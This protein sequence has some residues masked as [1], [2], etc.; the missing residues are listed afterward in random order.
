M[1]VP[2]AALLF[3]AGLL[4]R[5]PR[6]AIGLERILSDYFDIPV[7]VRQ[8]VGR[9]RKLDPEQWTIIG[10]RKKRNIRLGQTTTVGTRFWDK[11]THIRVRLGPMPRAKFTAMLPGGSAHQA[12]RDLI[13]FYLDPEITFSLEL[14]LREG[15]AWSP[16][17]GS[18]DLLNGVTSWL[19]PSDPPSGARRIRR[20]VVRLEGDY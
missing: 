13:S 16:M 14:V 19:A 12:V 20:R 10:G 7:K 1:A 3:Y 5:R 8:F 17:L 2:D 11:Q 4:S 9:W 18:D 6:S 15:D